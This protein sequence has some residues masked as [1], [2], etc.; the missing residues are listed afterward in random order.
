MPT[1]MSF[2]EPIRLHKVPGQGAEDVLVGETGLVYTGTEDGKIHEIDPTAGTTR[3]VGKT[4]G[5]PLGLEWLETGHMLICDSHRGLLDLD[6]STGEVKSLLTSVHGRKMIFC[7]NAAVHSSGSIYFSDSSKHHSI[8]EWKADVVEDTKSGRLMRLDPD[9]DVSVLIEGLRFANGVA[10]AADESYVIVAET[11]GRSV[12]RRWLTGSRAGIVENFATD[13]PGY[14]DNVSRGTDGLMWVTI[15]SPPD[16]VL[17]KVLFKAPMGLRRLVLRLP[18]A[19][20]PKPQ[21][22][23]RVMAFDDKGKLVHDRQLLADEFHMVTGVREHHG[24]VW[25]GSLVEPAVAVFDL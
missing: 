14:P 3:V 17:E 6:L 21:R 19:V 1:T 11:T 5:R 15:A 7:N 13:L 22:T 9:G 24:K 20:Q 18:E 16:P 2:D 4:N 25:L 12:V 8:D 23:A 10:L